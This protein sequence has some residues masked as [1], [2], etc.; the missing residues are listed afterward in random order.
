MKSRALKRRDGFSVVEVLAAI[1]LIAVAMIP[2]YRLQQTLANASF[3][4]ERTAE[5]LE[6][7]ENAL[8]WLETVNPM[9]EP[10]GE[11]EIGGWR[12]AWH[13]EPVASVPL[14]EGFRGPSNYALGLYEVEV[15]V[16]RGPVRDSFTI[17]KLGWRLV[18]DPLNF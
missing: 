6:A 4:I 12:V 8:A 17:R 5:T 2:L 18:R 11:T 14:A 7:K 3:R 10:D 9:I 15:S 1:A 16:E 13:A